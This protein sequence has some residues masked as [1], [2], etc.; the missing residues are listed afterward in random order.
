MEHMTLNCLNMTNILFPSEVNDKL[1]KQKIVI[2]GT[3]HYLVQRLKE[4][5]QTFL[6]IQ[7]STSAV[8]L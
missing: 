4:T 3:L 2:A 7:K 6:N 1:L 5:E 8:R